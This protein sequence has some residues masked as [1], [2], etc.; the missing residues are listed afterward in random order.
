M[1]R[2]LIVLILLPSFSLAVPLHYSNNKNI[3]IEGD[4]Q[5]VRSANAPTIVSTSDCLG[6]YSAGGQH[7]LLGL[8]LGGTKESKPC[9]IR[10]FSKIYIAIGDYEA[11]HAV[12]CQ[13]KIIKDALQSINKPC[14]SKD[15]V[16]AVCAYPTEECKK[17][18][19]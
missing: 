4:K 6:S 10:E 8:S 9:N 18:K 16:K 13:S 3:V 2:F 5:P 7:Q 17:S 12:L 1:I 15:D 14:P 19:R 11:A